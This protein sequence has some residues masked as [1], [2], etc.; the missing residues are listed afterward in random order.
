M[1]RIFGTGSVYSEDTRNQLKQVMAVTGQSA[2]AIYGKTG[3]GKA[4]GVT[5]DA[6]FAGMAETEDRTLYFCVYLGETQGQQVSS[7]IAREIAV[8][9]LT[10]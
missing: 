3:M 10:E 4:H 9:I 1:E 8:K 2:P 7:A 6:W 5:V